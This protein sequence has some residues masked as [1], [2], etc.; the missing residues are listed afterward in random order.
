MQGALLLDVVIR[1]GTAILELLAS[2]DKTLLIRG[3]TFLIL[4][5]HKSAPNN[6]NLLAQHTWIFLFTVSMVSLDSTSRVMVLPVRVYANSTSEHAHEKA[7][8]VLTQE[9]QNID[10][11]ITCIT[12]PTG[13]AAPV[14]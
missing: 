3:N 13:K 8:A 7:K 9:E 5:P 12:I 6:L 10:R 11:A 4:S 14:P 2:E 1:K